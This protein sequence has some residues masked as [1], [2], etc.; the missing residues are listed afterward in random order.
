VVESDVDLN[1]TGKHGRSQDMKTLLAY[2]WQ[3]RCCQFLV[4]AIILC[5]TPLLHPFVRD[6]ITGRVHGRSKTAWKSEIRA[7]AKREEPP[8]TWLTVLREKLGFERRHE[9]L[10]LR[11]ERF[12]PIIVELTGDDDNLVRRYCL[13]LLD[14]WA[15]THEAAWVYEAHL[16]DCDPWCR[17]IAAKGAWHSARNDVTAVLLALCDDKDAAIRGDV[18]WFMRE[19]IRVA[20]NFAEALSKLA[21]DDNHWVTFHARIGLLGTDQPSLAIVRKSLQDDNFQV[22]WAAV[23]AAKSLGDEAAKLIPE[24]LILRQNESD[25]V[26]R[27]FAGLVLSDLDAKR[28]RVQRN[29][30][31]RGPP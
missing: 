10:D 17:L 29:L 13:G 24:L 27:D 31:E 5:L 20:P 4:V 18:A 12:L 26:L 22:R 16:H 14:Q 6:T 9:F 8:R 2:I 15:Y 1:L 7:R 19:K 11:D 23:M 21:D 30:A 3:R 25:V 28:F